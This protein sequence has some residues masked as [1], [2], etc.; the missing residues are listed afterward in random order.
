M[1]QSMELHK[2]ITYLKQVSYLDRLKH[3]KITLLNEDEKICTNMHLEDL[4]R[5]IGKLWY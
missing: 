5:N 2:K 4:R 1:K 3:N